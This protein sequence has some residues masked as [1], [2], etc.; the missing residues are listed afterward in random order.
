MEVPG[1]WGQETA[2]AGIAVTNIDGDPRPEIVIFHIDQAPGANQGYYRVGWN[3]DQQ[4][5][6]SNWSQHVAFGDWWGE[7]TQGA[8]LTTA[9]LTGNGR[10]ELIAMH[11][12]NPRGENTAYYRVVYD[13]MP[14]GLPA[15]WSIAS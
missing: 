8:G 4:G 2:G 10:P 12:D 9:E 7:S 13:L 15:E 6:T 14:N 1:W 5:Y 3:V 11:I